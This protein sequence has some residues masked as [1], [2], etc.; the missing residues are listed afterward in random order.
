MC[1]PKC[2]RGADLALGGTPPHRQRRRRP[3]HLSRHALLRTLAVGLRPHPGR[4]STTSGSPNSPSG[5]PKCRN[6]T[7]TDST[8]RPSKRA[9]V[10]RRRDP[11][12]SATNTS[13]TRRARAIRGCTRGRRET[14]KFKVGD[15]VTVRELPVLFYTRTPEYVRGA[16]GEIAYTGLREPGGRGRDVGPAGRDGRVVLRRELQTGRPV[17][18]LHRHRHRHA[19][20]R[21]PRALA[22]SRHLS[23]IR[24]SVTRP[25][26]NGA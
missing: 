9:E 18:R 22:P 25:R 15:T 13:S 11:T 21:D 23:R 4:K 2:S 7:P 24:V 6:A 5:W 17:G 1:C 20:H 16:T 10:R 14:A 19:A 8:A 12:S 3:G 26:P